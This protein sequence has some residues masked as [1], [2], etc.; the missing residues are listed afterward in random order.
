MSTIAISDEKAWESEVLQSEI[1]VFVDFWAAWCGP[2]RMV[3][4]VV[5]ELAGE[6]ENKVKFVKVNIDEAGTLASN[7]NV[8]S[9]PTLLLINKGQ[10]I[11]QQAGAASKDSYKDMIDK[12]LA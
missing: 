9:I 1:P 4:P 3:S 5:D 7:Y 6:Y 2:C 8:Y 10:V 12:A 11:A